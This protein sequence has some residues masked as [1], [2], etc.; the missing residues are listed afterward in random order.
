MRFATSATFSPRPLGVGSAAEPT[1]GS[2]RTP[3]CARRNPSPPASSRA[4]AFK[5]PSVARRARNGTTFFAAR[6]RERGRGARDERRRGGEIGPVVVTEPGPHGFDS[7][8]FRPAGRARREVG[9]EK[10]LVPFQRL[11]PGEADEDEV[12]DFQSLAAFHD[13]SPSEKWA[14]SVSMARKI[15]V[16]TAPSLMSSALAISAYGIP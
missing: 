14:L 1:R 9:G 6:G 4:A 16:F 7:R 13:E 11:R 15:R 12:P 3:L 8:R 10:R 5:S 2:G